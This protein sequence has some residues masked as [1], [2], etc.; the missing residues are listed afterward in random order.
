MITSCSPGWVRFIEKNFPSLL[1][2]LSTC[3][4]P[5]QMFGAIIKSYYAKK[6][7]IDPNKIYMDC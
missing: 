3:K 4:S 5:H 6:C 2:H 1:D 7:N